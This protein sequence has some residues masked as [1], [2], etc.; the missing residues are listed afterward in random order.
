MSEVQF[1]IIFSCL[2]LIYAGTIKDQSGARITLHKIEKLMDEYNK[3]LI[4]VDA[5]AD[6]P[7]SNL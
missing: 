4:H 7:V 3:E 2:M 5:Q 1:R 6:Q